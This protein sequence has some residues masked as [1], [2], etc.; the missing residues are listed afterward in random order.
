MLPLISVIIPVYNT[1]DYII[2]CIDSVRKQTYSN[3]EVIIVNDGSTDDSEKLITEFIDQYHLTYFSII[4]KPN[5]GLC[6]A[7]NE[8]L[9][10][11]AGEWVVF[12]DSDDWIEPRY[13]ESMMEADAQY[14]AE[15]YLAGFRAYDMDTNVFDVWSNYT[16]EFGALPTD[17]HALKSC[18]YVWARMYKKSVI[19]KH[20]LSF[21]ERVKFCEDNAFNFDYISVAQSFACVNEVGYT[22]R[23]GHSGAMSKQAVTPYMR[24]YIAEHM[25]AFCDKVPMGDIV[26][27]LDENKSFSR[28]MWNTQLTDVVIDILEKNDASA[29]RKMK[30]P[31]ARNIVDSFVPTTRKD[32][33]YHFLWNR[34]FF[35]FKLFVNIFYKN[36]EKIKKN[37][38]LAHFLTH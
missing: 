20:S 17:L 4:N 27:A 5:G 26:I 29:Q 21:D 23:R 10:H 18:D 38:R 12:V 6:S 32:K 13:I 22:Y 7:R 30:Q 15:L 35:V 16:V 25:Y 34:S 11:A 36:V 9:K 24:R 8:G 1:Q 2:G 33:M 28:I 19:D 37:K 31:L 14:H 3:L